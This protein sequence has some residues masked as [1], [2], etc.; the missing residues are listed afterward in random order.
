MNKTWNPT[1][2]VVTNRLNAS[3]YRVLPAGSIF[4]EEEQLSNLVS[5]CNQRAI[6]DFLFKDR[7]NG[8]PYELDDAR[9]FLA[10]ASRGWQEQQHFV[11]LLVTPS[12]LISGALDIK[13]S[14]RT[15]AEIGYW[16]SELHRGLM[17]GAVGELKS[18]AREASFNALFGRVRKDNAASIK[19]LERNGFALQGNWPGDPTR[20][21]Y[22]VT[23]AV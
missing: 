2:R 20:E 9:R 16:C 5:I 17:T 14:N 6:Y 15:M 3:A 10:W 23:L 22:E 8:R 11:F 18:L 4:P 12:G 1:E 21:R 13:S 7:F 19:V